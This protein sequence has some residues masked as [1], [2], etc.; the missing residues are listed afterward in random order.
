MPIPLAIP[1]IVAGI[2]A[3]GKFFSGAKQ[4]KESKKINPIW[5]QYQTNPFAKKQLETAQ[6]MFGG[7]MAGAPQLQQNIFSSQANQLD[8]VSRNATDSSQAL[9]LGAASQGQTNQSLADLQIQEAQNKQMTLGNLNQAYGTMIGEGDKTY[10]SLLQKY[11]MDAQRKDALRS[12]GA[13]NKYGAFSDLASMGFQAYGLSKGMNIWGGNN[14]LKQF[15][16]SG[17]DAVQYGVDTY[18][19][20]TAPRP[21]YNP[22][23]GKI[24]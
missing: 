22:T 3:F 2:G 24:E 23:T 8:N 11:Q 16:G 18:K 14:S 6:Q 9:E 7:R 13:Q 15:G 17:M 20:L 21:K 19:K 5:Q 1:A 10:E 4:V 12:S